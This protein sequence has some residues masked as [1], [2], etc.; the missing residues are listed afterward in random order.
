[1]ILAHCP[2]YIARLFLL[3]CHRPTK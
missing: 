2:A 1:M 3:N